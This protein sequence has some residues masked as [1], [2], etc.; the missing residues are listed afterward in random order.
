MYG[1]GMTKQKSKVKSPIITC[2]VKMCIT[3]DWH[4]FLKFLTSCPSIQR[5]HW[6]LQ[7]TLPPHIFI[8]PCPCLP[9]TSSSASPSFYARC[10]CHIP[11]FLLRCWGR[12]T[13]QVIIAA[14]R[15]AE[16]GLKWRILR[17]VNRVKQN[18]LWL[19]F[20]LLAHMSKKLLLFAQFRSATDWLTGRAFSTS[21]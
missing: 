21:F 15:P 17:C 20:S 10:C 12:T 3:M 11:T 5:P 16:L 14:D 4:T 8:F 13:V 19:S 18:S 2:N 7:S 6:D 9:C 1:A